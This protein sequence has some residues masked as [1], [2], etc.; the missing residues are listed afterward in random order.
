MCQLNRIQILALAALGASCALLPPT[1]YAQYVYSS[2][3]QYGSW[4]D[5]SWTIYN[6]AWGISDYSEYPQTLNIT[7]INQWNVETNQVGGGV[8]S[9]PN[10]EV[11]PNTPLSQMSA[12]SAYFNLSSPGGSEYD[13]IFDVYTTSGGADQI[14]IYESWNTPTGGWGSQI[15]SNVTIGQS[16]YSQVWQV[17][18]S[19]SFPYNVL[20][21]FRSNQ[22]TSG[23]ED[24]LAITNW[25]ASKGLLQDQ[26][27]YSVS[28]G[29]EIT[30]TNGTQS[31]YLNELDS[32][33][34]NTSGGGSGITA[35]NGE[36]LIPNGNYVIKNKNSG[37]VMDVSGDSTAKG[38]GIDQWSSTGGTNQIW[39]LSNVGNNYVT[40][41]SA[42]SGME[43]D[44][45]GASKSNGAIM[46]QWPDNAGANQVW[47]VVS[48]GSGYY[49]LIGENSG[50]AL[51][52]PSYSTSDGTGLD[53]W[54]VNGGSNQLWSFA[55]TN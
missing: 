33:W 55:S 7:S 22:R 46:D 30:Y 8:K 37:L 25:C 2:N 51:E 3:A 52:V 47:H 35:G 50:L 6:D 27:F 20:M 28:F 9:Y 31:F 44:V 24:I 15:Y 11:I 36:Y 45:N 48:V 34:S 43:I 1:A 12:A 17:T 32:V 41:T 40:L 19:T 38:A 21:F 18:P 13:W 49:E 10:T 39:T 14:Q 26:S 53:Q 29:P 5:G 42:R 16:T 23:Y 4:S 54:T